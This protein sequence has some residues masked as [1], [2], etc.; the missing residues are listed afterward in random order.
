MDSNHG[1]SGLQPNALQTELLPH[2]FKIVEDFL[3]KDEER[4]LLEEI[5]NG[6]WE[7]DGDKIRRVQQFGAKYDYK[8]HQID[9]E[10]KVPQIPKFLQFVIKRL[11]SFSSSELQQVFVNEYV[12]H[13]GIGPH[14][15]PI[16]SFGPEIFGISLGSP[17]VL[18]FSRE[19]FV[20]IDVL[21]KPR[22]LL[23]M[24]EDSRYLWKHEIPYTKSVVGFP[25]R[26]KGFRRISLTFRGIVQPNEKNIITMTEI[27]EA[28]KIQ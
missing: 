24:T 5:D 7:G 25:R 3:S 14:I 22:S 4:F 10:A 8:T 15:D 19:G 28:K 23:I 11:A 27:S 12:H 17:T 9:R 2:G 6:V 16:D 20:S 26:Q 13:Q 1:P 18:R 21:L